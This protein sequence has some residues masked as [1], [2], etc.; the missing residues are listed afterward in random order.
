MKL[1]KKL[2]L[3][4]IAI[5]ACFG[6]M[7]L[8]SAEDYSNITNDY[9]T[10]TKPGVKQ[11][12]YKGEKIKYNVT[13]TNP[14]SAN[15]AIPYV[16]IITVTE[17][18]YKELALREHDTLYPGAKSILKNSFNTKNIKA[19][20]YYFIVSVNQLLAN[21]NESPDQKE[22]AGKMIY[23]KTL[24]APKSVKAKSTKKGIKITYQKATGATKY[25]I[26][27]STDK[28]SGFKRVG[29]TT[30]TEF[31]NKKVTKGKKYYYK[32]KSVRAINKVVTSKYSL[33][34]TAVA[35]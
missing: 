4:A 26:Y 32:V 13:V 34:V 3:P 2:I 30:K 8:V 12:Y 22:Q 21:G 27:R 33:K 17:N 10:I 19:G 6:F 28:T 35:K 25:Y 1:I 16:G 18:D 7:N 23:I 31:L 20:K 29:K 14:W 11:V 5:A 24:K 9:A 15:K